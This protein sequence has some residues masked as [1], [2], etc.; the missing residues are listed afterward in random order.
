MTFPLRYEKERQLGKGGGGEVWAVKDRLTGS[1]LALKVLGAAASDAEIMAL[2]REAT[3]LS[4]LEGLGVP[5]VIAF[6]TLPDESHARY[7]VRELVPG[8]SLQ[9]V[10]ERKREGDTTASWLGPLLDAADQ[11]TVLHRAGLLHGDVKPA[12][13]IVDLGGRGTLVD[14]GLA[15]PLTARGTRARGLT[16]R[17]A[18]PELLVGE[19]LTVRAEVYALGA[20]LDMAL[21]YRAGRLG[22][23]QAGRLFAIAERATRKKPEDRYPSADE[24]AQAIRSAEG[25]SPPRNG[26]TTALPV[27]GVDAMAHDLG[28]LLAEPGDGEAASF[29]TAIALTGGEGSGRSTLA[30]R[31][32]WTLGATGRA[33]AYL[34]PRRL[35][36]D[37]A[38]AVKIERETWKARA[39]ELCFVVDDWDALSASARREVLAACEAGAKL[40]GVAA[41]DLFPGFRKVKTFA[42]P[43]LDRRSARDLVQRVIPSLSEALIEYLVDASGALPGRLRSALVQLENQVAVSEPEIDALFDAS[44]LGRGPKTATLADL[45]TALGKG[46]I[47]EARGMLEHLASSSEAEA[48]EL[49]VARS[50]IA[51]SRGELALAVEALDDVA[52][53]AAR[54]DDARAYD[55]ARARTSLRGGDYEAARAAAGRAAMGAEDDIAAEAISVSGVAQAFQGNEAEAEAELL[56]AV[57]AAEASGSA[58]AAAVAK[59]S[60]AIAH[61]RAGRN[62]AARRAYEAALEAAE[63]ASDAWTI[64]TTRLNLGA[65]VRTQGDLALAIDHL[66][67]AIDMGE[68]A[69]AAMCVQQARFNLA[70]LD[71]YLGRYGRARASIDE[72]G[73]GRERLEPAAR[74][75]LLGL[76]AELYD[77]TEEPARAITLYESCALAYEIIGRPME[78][79]EA[80]LEALLLR[81]RDPDAEPHTLAR[82]LEALRKGLGETGFSEHEALAE[83]VHG[84]VAMLRSDEA[85]AK[86]CFDAAVHA[87]RTRQRSEW[88]WRALEARARLEGLQGAQSLARRDTEEARGI[89]EETASRLP[90]DLREVFW[91]DPRRRALRE[92]GPSGSVHGTPEFDRGGLRSVTATRLPAEDRLA[93]LFE[94]TRDLA[95]ERDLSALLARVTDHAIAIVGAER[96]FIVL[97]DEEGAIVAHT[98]RGPKGEATHQTFSRS[99]AEKV[100]ATGEPVIAQSAKDDA[101]LAEAVSVHQLMIQSIAC[102]PIRGLSPRGEAIGA[103]YLETRLRPAHRF[104]AELPMLNAFADQA[105]IAIESARL[106]EQNQKRAEELEAANQELSKTKE[107]LAGLLG[108]RT[109][110]LAATR[111]DLRQVKAEIRS[112]FGYAGL[113]GKSEAM[114]RVYAILDRVRD[115]DVP[116]LLTGES[117]SGK[118]MVARAIHSSGVRAKGPFVGVNCGA[119]PQNLL[120]SE[121]FGHVRGS[122]TGADRDHKGLFRQAS[123]G[124]ILLDE[125]GE[126]PQSMQSAL[127]RVL[128]EKTVRPVGA[129]MEEAVDVRIVAATNRNLEEMVAA[130]TFREDLFYRLHVVELRV[131]AL[132]EREGDVPLLVDHF[133]S[134]FSA[135]YRRDKKTVNRE[136]QRALTEYAWPGNVRQLEHVLLNAWLMSEGE[137]IELEDLS[138]PQGRRETTESTRRA[139]SSTSSTSSGAPSSRAPSR[140]VRSKEDFRDSERERILQALQDSQWNRVQAAKIVGMPRRTFYRRLKEYG[141]L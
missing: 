125:I 57:A 122:F 138:L 77:R 105:A 121:L 115:A 87:A 25:L 117:G 80:R 101:R 53:L 118:E 58:R 119:I 88:A 39:N 55:L 73:K 90:R 15:A 96:G 124:T 97:A 18:A 91:N 126:L 89:L 84:T 133:L 30:R 13:I 128:Q 127:L 37:H 12:N 40:V 74:A 83:L 32:A 47:G 5:M 95:R 35:T 51:L 140:E 100:V 70:N 14:L 1:T 92:S 76:E 66:Q 120:E 116:V 41:A 82:E 106:L 11:L 68:R 72:L 48:L 81:A 22:D 43:P 61:Q 19:P 141:I 67:A 20:S 113:V 50:R 6:G 63:R 135:R 139:S 10:L 111:R 7:L 69:G 93:R 17:F 45:R 8:M 104:Q 71:L 85:F 131:P 56:R 38:E 23:D 132:R 98:A 112:H 102:I 28:Q 137:E 62:D 86:S 24:L 29:G 49:G 21:E 134:L 26:T 3:A 136:A 129:S 44:M 75:Q 103:L 107:R 108:R 9:D 31:L 65:L 114:R 2:V 130:G 54:A 27:H 60:L 78:A 4:G 16:P 33:V 36:I 110:Q 34:E 94:I 64:A 59:G 123:G 79:L 99:V 42:M 52:A 109:E 46:R